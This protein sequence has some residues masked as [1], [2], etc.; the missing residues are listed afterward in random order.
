MI[1]KTLKSIQTEVINKMSLSTSTVTNYYSTKNHCLH[2]NVYK[3]SRCH[4]STCDLTG[5]I[6]KI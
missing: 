6:R 4:D 3:S 1:K 5:S 2:F